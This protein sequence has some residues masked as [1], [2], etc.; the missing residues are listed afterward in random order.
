M[1]VVDLEKHSCFNLIDS[2]P[3]NGKINLHAKDPFKAKHQ[4]LITKQESTGLKYCKD[5]KAFT[6]YSSDTDDIYNNVQ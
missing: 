6:E 4:L 5:Y 1:E 2:L 3:D